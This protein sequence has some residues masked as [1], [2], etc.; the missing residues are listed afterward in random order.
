[1]RYHDV[2]ST[3][4]LQM[5]IQRPADDAL[6]RHILREWVLERIVGNEAKRSE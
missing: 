6:R 3:P 4:R 5:E 2:L 1:M